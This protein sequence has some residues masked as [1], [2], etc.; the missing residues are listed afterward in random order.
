MGISGWQ[1]SRR[2]RRSGMRD[3]RTHAPG[4]PSLHP[5]NCSGGLSSMTQVS[6]RSAYFPQPLEGKLY[7]LLMFT[8]P[9]ALPGP[10]RR[11]AEVSPR[12]A[13][14]AGATLALCSLGSPFMAP[15]SVPDL[16]LTAVGGPSGGEGAPDT[17]LT[18]SQAVPD[19]R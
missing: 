4:G 16:Q 9:A 18:S 8:A 13:G 10:L 17:C 5:R 7:A 3:I 11:T 1:P 2:S 14:A 19:P 6:P 15:P 12:K